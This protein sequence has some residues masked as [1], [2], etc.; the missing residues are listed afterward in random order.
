MWVWGHPP[1]IASLI[2]LFGKLYIAHCDKEG[3][4]VAVTLK[5]L[6]FWAIQLPEGHKDDYQQFPNVEESVP[7]WDN[8]KTLLL[9]ATSGFFACPKSPLRGQES[10]LIG[11][12]GGD[13][14]NMD[15]SQLT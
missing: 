10:W 12:V 6:P 4:H 15:V 8:F 11:M 2:Y 9:Q 7:V 1:N 14:G 3:K 13:V 5:W